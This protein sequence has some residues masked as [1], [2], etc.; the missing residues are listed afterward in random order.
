MIVSI[1]TPINSLAER[2]LLLQTNAR[3]LTYA[4]PTSKGWNAMAN[5]ATIQKTVDFLMTI[6]PAST[7]ET[8][9]TAELYPNVAAI[10]SVYGDSD[11]KYV[12]FLNSSGFPYADDP[13][14]LWDQ[15]LAGGDASSTSSSNSTSG[16][17]PSS[18]KSGAVSSRVGLV[19]Q[20]SS[21]SLV[22]L[23]S[24]LQFL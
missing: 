13:T 3:L 22:L 19:G 21:L 5:G 8:N 20:L 11:G 7:S 4:A 12:K 6:N 24:G 10:A 18:G 16:P 15:P 2:T 14:F 17:K 23:A 1:R 9:V